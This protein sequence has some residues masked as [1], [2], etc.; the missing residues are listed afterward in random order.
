MRA[1]NICFYV[2]LTKIMPNYHQIFVWVESFK[3]FFFLSVT[4]I[5]GVVFILFAIT[6]FMMGPD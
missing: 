2:E 4:L 6:A 5:G 1:H 3:I